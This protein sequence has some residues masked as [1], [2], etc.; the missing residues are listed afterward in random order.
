MHKTAFKVSFLLVFLF[1]VGSLK[2]QED[3]IV[4]LNNDTIRGV[5]FEK[6]FGGPKFLAAGKT[7]KERVMAPKTREYFIY[8]SKKVMSAQIIPGTKDP[9][10]LERIEN[11]RIKLYRLDQMMYSYSPSGGATNS[12]RQL[13]WYVSKDNSPIKTLK[14]NSWLTFSK[15]R[16]KNEFYEIIKDNESVA[17]MFLEKEK[18]SFDEIR[19]LVSIYN[20]DAKRS[21]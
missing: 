10:F 5:V 12:S 1:F 6:S 21:F 19:K 3:F 2:A 13:Y 9:I 11:G 17:S 15:E 18:F 20:A 14:H 4:T 8:S 16:R 7:K